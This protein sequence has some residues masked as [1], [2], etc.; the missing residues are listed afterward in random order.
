VKRSLKQWLMCVLAVPMISA[1]G[2]EGDA[3][4]DTTLPPEAAVQAEPLVAEKQVVEAPADRPRTPTR[5]VQ[6]ENSFGSPGI[7]TAIGDKLGMVL[8]DRSGSM[9]T[10]RSATGNTRCVDAIRQARI[11]L[12]ALFTDFGRTH[13]AVWSFHGSIVTKHT[14]G[15]VT[16][17]TAEA[18]I[19]AVE[20]AG[21]TNDNTP[22]AD[23]MCWAID[24]LSSQEPGQSTHLYIA[25]DGYE[26]SSTGE[27]DSTTSGDP[28]TP[29]T[30]QNKVYTRATNKLVKTSTN[31][32]VSATDLEFAPSSGQTDLLAT[33]TG[34]AACEEKLFSMLATMSG[35]DYRRAKD[36]NVAYP[37]SSTASCPAPYNGTTGNKFAF[38]T[39]TTNNAT[40]NTV[41]QGIYLLAGETLTVGTCGVTGATATGDA[42]MR[43][44]GLTG[45]QVAA[46]DDSCGLHSKITYTAPTTG[47]YQVR[48]GCFANNPCSGTVAYTISGAFPPYTATG[49]NNATV[50]TVNRSVY[51]RP[52]QR[53]QVGTCGVPGATASAPSDTFLRL[54]GS[55]GTQVAMNDQGGCGGTLGNLSYISYIVPATGA[56]RSEVR[57]GCFSS[58]A[59]G[60]TVSY[61]LTDSSV[62]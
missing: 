23:A 1:C 46:A 25:T 8:I 29:G 14:L 52:G 34:T 20:T 21:C 6:A 7:Q 51:L 38:S 61:L 18:A 16:Q 57:A 39:S 55:A 22:L 27:C 47:T 50:N 13:V 19:N 3:P 17:A 58:V 4:S 48:T 35:G 42:S 40:T 24:D 44:F 56:G 12:A 37:C 33:C 2:A 62:P 53:I 30:W 43:L 49:T 26:N 11:E 28:L 32:F 5:L 31:Y 9:K 59:C 60:G 45:T 41:N 10:V 15:Y 36:N 54:F